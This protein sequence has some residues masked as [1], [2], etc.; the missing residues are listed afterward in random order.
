MPLTVFCGTDLVEIKRIRQ[1]AARLGQRFLD[2][3]WT[4]EEQADC[5]P[6]GQLTAAAAASLAARF[7]AKEAIAKALGTGIGRSGIRWTDLSVRRLPDGAPTVRLGSA[8]EAVYRRLDG[9]SLA[10][11]LSHEREIALAFCVLIS[12]VTPQPEQRKDRITG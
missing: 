11:S 9:Q 10:I 8:A 7:A 4:A 6:D 12:G 1:A 3:I 5:L 2:R